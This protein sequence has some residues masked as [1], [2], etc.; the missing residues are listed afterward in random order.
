MT[1]S[2]PGDMVVLIIIIATVVHHVNPAL[3]GAKVALLSNILQVMKAD[4][5]VARF[6]AE[7][8]K[9]GDVKDGAAVLE[10]MTD[11]AR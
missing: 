8:V 2:D 11:G 7:E 1:A 5:E 3:E 4:D 9:T 10:E 6:K